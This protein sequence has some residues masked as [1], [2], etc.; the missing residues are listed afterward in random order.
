MV[1]RV[2]PALYLF[3]ETE[4]WPNLLWTLRE[5]GVPSVLVNGRLSSRDHLAGKTFLAFVPSGVR[6]SLR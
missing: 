6:C 3:V 1:G 5:H 2:K 4:L